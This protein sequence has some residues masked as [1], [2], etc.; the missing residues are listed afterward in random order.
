MPIYEY[1]CRKCD[2]TF[3]V[4]QKVSEDNRDLQCPKCHTDRPER[5]LSSFCA[6]SAKSGGSPSRASGHSSPG[7][8]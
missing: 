1:R 4:M 6:G 8:S 2:E 5:L 3:E 7:H